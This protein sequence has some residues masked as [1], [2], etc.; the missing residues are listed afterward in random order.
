ESNW[1]CGVVEDLRRE[2]FIAIMMAMLCLSQ[3]NVREGGRFE[4]ALGARAAHPGI[5]RWIIRV[6]QKLDSRHRGVELVSVG[7]G[8]DHDQ[9][10]IATDDWVFLGFGNFRGGFD[11]PE[12]AAVV[13]ALAE[14]IGNGNM[15]M[16]AQALIGGKLEGGGRPLGIAGAG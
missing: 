16:K 10:P 15:T 6:A 13:A 14:G 8:F 2:C 12:E 4:I 5:E 3:A 7:T 11:V 9:E 1:F